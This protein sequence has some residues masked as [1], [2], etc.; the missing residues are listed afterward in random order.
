MPRLQYPVYSN[1]NIVYETVFKCEYS[2]TKFKLQ[3][4]ELILGYMN[5]HAVENKLRSIYFTWSIFFFL[6]SKVKIST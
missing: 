3:S 2:N 1:I 6:K 4:F 5:T